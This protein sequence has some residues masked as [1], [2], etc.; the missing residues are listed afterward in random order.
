MD[1]A[2]KNNASNCDNAE[3]G[4]NFVKKTWVIPQLVLLEEHCI[5][6]TLGFG[7]DVGSAPPGPTAS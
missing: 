3:L 6:G 4:I 5:N 1:S 7:S 2:L